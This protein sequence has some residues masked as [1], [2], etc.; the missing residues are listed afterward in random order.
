ML[1]RFWSKVDLARTESPHAPTLGRCW[2][3]IGARHGNGYGAFW[4]GERVVTAHRFSFGPVPEGLE[5]DHLCAN[6]ACI[7]PLHLEAVTHAENI[8]RG[9]ARVTHC[10]AG[11]PYDEANTYHHPTGSRDCRACMRIS[12]QRYR[13]AR[14]IS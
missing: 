11:H 13:D 4:D 5:L 3:W 6:R 12:R 8:R 7:R 14:R 2:V 9:A 1:G 10:P